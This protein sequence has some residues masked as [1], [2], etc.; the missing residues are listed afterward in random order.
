MNLKYLG[1]KYGGWLIDIESINDGDTILC[2]GVGEDISFEEELMK[3]KNIK[4]IE[5][6]PTEK[7][8]VYMKGKL[9]KYKNME[10]IKKAI[11]R[12]GIE[13]IT[14]HKNKNDNHVSESIFNDHRGVNVNEVYQVETISIEELKKKYNPSYI[15][16]D[17]EGSEYNVYKELLGVKQISIEFHHHCISTKTLQDTKNVINYFLNNGYLII[18]NRNLHE[19]TLLKN[20]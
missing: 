5:I 8:H 9:K 13:N 18:D 11:E 7:S 2:G 15:K 17:I 4:I 10:L 19:V 14:I 3:Y 20:D 1:T 6:D 12:S 16:I